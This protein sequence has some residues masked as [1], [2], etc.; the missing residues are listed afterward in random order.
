MGFISFEFL[1][2]FLIVLALYWLLP[3]SRWQNFLLFTASMVFYG[4]LVAWH[5]IVLLASIVVDYFL[6]LGMTRWKS[7]SSVLMWLGVF[8][9]VALIASV[10]YYFKYDNALAEWSLQ[11][12]I[13]GDFIL[14]GILLPLGVS[15]YTLKKISYLVDVQRGTMQ[16]LHDLFAFGAYV[17]FF[18]QVLSGPIDRPQTFLKQL[19]NPRI[20][21]PIHFYNAWQ[22]ILMGLFKK[23]VITN[24][25]KVLVDQIFL[26]SEPSKIF[27]IVG[28]LGFTLQILADFSSYTDL[29]RGAAFLLGLKTTENFNKPYL[30]LT[31]NDFWNRW[32][33]SL[34]VWLRDYIFFP[35][36]RALMRTRGLPEYIVQLLPPLI[37]MLVS[38]LW[39][40][41]GWTFIVWGLYYGVLIVIYQLLGIRSDQKS[42]KR[43]FTW[44]VMFVLIVFGWII[45][46]APSTTWLWHTLTVSPFANGSEEWIA[47]LVL[48][49]MIAFYASLLYIKYLLDQY[50]PNQ[51]WL[52]ALYYAAVFVATLI[53]MNSS[54]PDFIYFQF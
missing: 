23:I 32:H 29:S 16:P 14:S 27:L 35:I 17:S 33:I 22:L 31:P 38:G 12:S 47:S 42:A 36:R 30:A 46:R 11:T 52:H 41:T 18:P 15:F 5:V 4:W 39:H 9:N 44:L 51:I 6:A 21:A 48:S 8:L 53:F 3:K 43:F 25:V 10:K 34:S 28:G 19:K 40:G 13:A 49:V 26:I 45:F 20:W 2:F 37:T 1:Y 54:T 7:R 50:T 24:T